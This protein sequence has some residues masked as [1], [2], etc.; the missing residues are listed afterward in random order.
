MDRRLQLRR[1]IPWIE[2]TTRSADLCPSQAFRHPA[3]L[4]DT[5]IGFTNAMK[6]ALKL[7]ERGTC[8]VRKRTGMARVE[9][10]QRKFHAGTLVAKVVWRT[11]NSR[12]TCLCTYCT[13]SSLSI[14]LLNSQTQVSCL[15]G[16]QCYQV[17][18]R[19]LPPMLNRD[20]RADLG[21]GVILL[22]G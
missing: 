10:G 5:D 12:E 21:I 9:S 7:R 4:N 18:C 15:A 17:G 13:S 19:S 22:L 1:D 6:T 8:T 2:W 11:Q 3:T 20:H 16:L 14:M